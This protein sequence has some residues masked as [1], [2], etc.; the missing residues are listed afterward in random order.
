MFSLVW[1]QFTDAMQAK[2]EAAPTYKQIADKKD[3]IESMK[4]L[5]DI[6]FNILNQ[7]SLLHAIHKAKCGFFLQ[8]QGRQFPVKDCLEQLLL[9]FLVHS[10]MQILTMKFT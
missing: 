2:V 9:T 3:G 6:A 7:H 5:K 1:G 8:F 4:L 10:Y